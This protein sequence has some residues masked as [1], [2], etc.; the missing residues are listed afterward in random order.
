MKTNKNIKSILIIVGVV[1]AILFSGIII[2]ANL[3]PINNNLLYAISGLIG[4]IFSS[5][6]LAYIMQIINDKNLENQRQLKI[7]SLR[8]QYFSDVKY[9]LEQ[10]MKTLYYCEDSIVHVFPEIRC[11][12]NNQK[13]D[14][15]NFADTLFIALVINGN[16]DKY[17]NMNDQDRFVLVNTNKLLFK[18]EGASI[19]DGGDIIEVPEIYAY[20]FA[21]K[22]CC[23]TAFSKMQNSNNNFDYE[24]FS[25]QELDVVNFFAE[26]EWGIGSFVNI[27]VPCTLI[28]YMVYINMLQEFIHADFIPAYKDPNFPN[29]IKSALD[30]T[31]HNNEKTKQYI[32]EQ[33]NKAEQKLDS[34]VNRK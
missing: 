19:N 27:N 1:S 34:M 4:G 11:S 13:V 14:V 16:P 32:K 26:H 28:K 31:Y 21:L 5:T 25:Q 10:L 3:D 22:E 23:R 2:W 20:I 33:K 7:K 18:D 8:E 9:N 29:K 17:L 12:F 6:L 24:I 15:E 30:T